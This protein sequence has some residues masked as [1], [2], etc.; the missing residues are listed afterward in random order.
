MQLWSTQ[1][2]KVDLRLAWIVID[3]TVY[4]VDTNARHY[5]VRQNV[6]IS[7]FSVFDVL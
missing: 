2:G 5:V 7:T 3:L 1:A 4:G 6:D